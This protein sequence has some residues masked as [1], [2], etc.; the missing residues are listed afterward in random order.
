MEITVEEVAMAD[1]SPESPQQWT[2]KRRAALVLSILKGETSVPAELPWV[3]GLH[4]E[5]RPRALAGTP[6]R[7]K[8]GVKTV[9]RSAIAT[10]DHAD[11]SLTNT[12]SIR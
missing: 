8:G 7:R 4:R 3:G 12:S 6:T 9:A 11:T 10:A 2:A 5:S 1:E